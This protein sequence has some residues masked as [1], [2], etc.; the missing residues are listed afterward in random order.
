MNISNWQLTSVVEK[1]C[2]LPLLNQILETIYQYPEATNVY[3]REAP[4]A[5]K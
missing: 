3:L 2:G 5:K 1:S 4:Q